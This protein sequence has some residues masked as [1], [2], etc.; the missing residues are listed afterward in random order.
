[1]GVTEMIDQRFEEGAELKS[2]MKD[3]DPAT[4]RK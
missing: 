2:T 3:V 4:L 1:V